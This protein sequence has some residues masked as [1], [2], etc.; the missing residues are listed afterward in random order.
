MTDRNNDATTS[1]PV[2]EDI[3]SY[4][5]Q[6][7][8]KHRKIAAIWCIEDVKA[9]RPDLTDDQAW[10]LLQ[11]VQGSHD[12]DNGITWTTLETSADDLFGSSTET[13]EDEEGGV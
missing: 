8:A 5:L 3:D 12:A 11:Q 13:D 2:I 9:I 6:L 4:V 7:L 1:A 10:E